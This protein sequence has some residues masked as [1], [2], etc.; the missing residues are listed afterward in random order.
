MNDSAQSCTK[1]KLFDQKK[2]RTL[3]KSCQEFLEEAAAKIARELARKGFLYSQDIE[4]LQDFGVD[5]HLTPKPP[6]E[7]QKDGR[8]FQIPRLRKSIAAHLYSVLFENREKLPDGVLNKDLVAEL[9]VDRLLDFARLMG[10]GKHGRR[11]WW[12]RF[13]DVLRIESERQGSG[14]TLVSHAQ[15]ENPCRNATHTGAYTFSFEGGD[16]PVFTPDRLWQHLERLEECPRVS[17]RDLQGGERGMSGE[18]IVR[19]CRDFSDCVRDS[20]GKPHTICLSACLAFLQEIYPVFSDVGSE[21]E[22]KRGKNE[23]GENEE[24]GSLVDSLINQDFDPCH[25]P[26]GVMDAGD[27]SP[28]RRMGVYQEVQDLVVGWSDEECR[29]FCKETGRGR[30]SQKKIAIQGRL[31]KDVLEAFE[32]NP[33][34]DLQDARKPLEELYVYLAQEICK[35]R[36]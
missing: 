28:E 23:E 18:T 11:A 35:L 3:D 7:Q 12:K 33:L 21:S 24:Y 8:Q 6:N 1:E 13:A 10:S 34:A 17:M 22:L 4:I 9:Y 2:Y 25:L 27:F 36:F 32:R 31:L 15:T 26:V 16:L 19:L 20:L 14:F 29:I 5:A 30:P